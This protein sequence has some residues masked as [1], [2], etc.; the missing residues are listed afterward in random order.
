[1]DKVNFNLA[2]KGD[3]KTHSGN[4]KTKAIKWCICTW[5]V[6]LATPAFSQL[7]VWPGD[8]NND[9]VVNTTDVLYLGLGYNTQGIARNTQGIVWQ[10]N[11][12]SPW[13][14]VL[15]DSTNYAYLDCDGNGFVNE[16]DLAAI[17]QNY[18]LTHGNIIIDS[19]PAPTGN[20]PMFYFS[21]LPDSI[22]QG[23]TVS[24]DVFAG[25]TVLPAEF[26]GIAMAFNYDTNLVVA[27]SITI[28]PDSQI[29]SPIESVLFLTADNI[30]GG[31]LEFALSRRANSGGNTGTP[32]VLQGQKLVSI[33]FIIEDNLIGK[34]TFGPL[35]ISISNINMLSTTVQKT[36]AYDIQASIPFTD[37][38]AV[39]PSP[40]LV[41]LRI[42]PQ[43]ASGEFVLEGL[44]IEGQLTIT[45][46]SG[47]TVITQA[48]QGNSHEAIN[49]AHL[50]KG[51]YLL[52][53]Q[54]AEGSIVKKVLID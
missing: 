15:A 2:E 13:A 49:C 30:N 43:P 24:I 39:A 25:D 51:M 29:N 17:S 1:M 32:I 5:M 36:S 46:L 27:N 23:D 11:P 28:T 20:S 47:R 40:S 3:N 37:V 10:G 50:A 41:Q 45:D 26:F 44:T 14:N 18:G 7:Q 8:A 31:K 6:L 22:N 35:A 19:F 4:M 33:N 48:L 9:G 38:V 52:H 12:V 42:Y 54:T 21:G 34:T 53:L 16:D